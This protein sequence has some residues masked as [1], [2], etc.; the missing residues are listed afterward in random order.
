M[1]EIT[2]E[3]SKPEGKNNACMSEECTVTFEDGSQ[4]T[5]RVGVMPQDYDAARANQVWTPF[6]TTWSEKGE[7]IDKDVVEKAIAEWLER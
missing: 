6:I 3:F 4:Q 7:S 5:F 1:S 2:F